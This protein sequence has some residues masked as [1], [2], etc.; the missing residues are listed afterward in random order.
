[1]F[2]NWNA[3]VYIGKDRRAE[4][5]KMNN[6][7]LLDWIGANMVWPWEGVL[8]TNNEYAKEIHE[9][10][11]DHIREKFNQLTRMLVDEKD[12]LEELKKYCYERIEH[13]KSLDKLHG[14]VGYGS[15][16]I[17]EL[18]LVI[19]TIKELKQSYPLQSRKLNVKGKKDQN[20]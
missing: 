11:T 20:G 5:Q 18:K 9:K 14:V 15:D 8:Q 10:I 3:F 2:I 1:M 13:W 12:D 7:K 16:E 17:M 6:K 19:A 4:K